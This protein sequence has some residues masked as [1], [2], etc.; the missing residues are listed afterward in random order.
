M[1]NRAELL[2]RKLLQSL[3][4]PWQ[5]LL[6][7]SRVE[8][9]L[10]AEKI[11][12]RNSVYRPVVTLWIMI[13]QA[14]D[15]D[16]SLSNAVKR[17]L[18]WLS[19]AGETC[20]SADTGAYSKA[21]KR[22]PEG[23]LRQ[24]IP[25][26]ADALEEQVPIE[27]QWCGRRVRVYDGTPV[28]MSDT[29]ANQAAYPQA[30]TQRVGCGFPIANV[31]VVF[32]LLTGAVVAGCI[33]AHDCGEI[34][35]SRLLYQNLHPEEVVLADRA[36]GN[37]VDLAGVQQQGA[38]GVFRKNQARHSD[39]RRGKRLGVRDHL[40]VWRKPKMRPKHM[41]VAEFTALPASLEV[42]EVAFCVARRGF[43]TQKLVVVTT[44]LDAKRY[45]AEQLSRLYGLRWQAAEV[46][47]RHLK[48]TLKLERVNAK[49]P[50]MVRKE[51]WVHLLGYTLLRT[52]MWQSAT[53]Q[54]RTPFQL[55]FQGARQQFNQL[56]SL[57]ATLTNAVRKQLYQV[58]L[59]QI[60]ADLLPIRAHRSEP[61]V[62]KRRPKPFPRMQ[63][64]RAVLKA[65][66]VK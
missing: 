17:V 43:R 55:S 11:V 4:L 25:E 60:A 9:I 31:V 64:P 56:L 59:E 12:Y 3:A 61:R 42:R 27:Q 46:N 24:L 57:L 35:M 40:V 8:A 33:A 26:V 53:P 30:K 23:L 15:P 39:F 45:S 66:L 50:E 63:Q 20:P 7:N 18:S 49:T 37:Y 22:L 16:K 19:A 48:T 58:L 10:D 51:I 1:P 38:D 21:R 65:K 6:P 52:L 13:G 14:L 29:A 54:K 41:S 28:L 5:T 47:L 36:Y 44:F 34:V 32:S 62:V 2:K